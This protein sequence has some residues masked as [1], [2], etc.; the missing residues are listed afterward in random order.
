MRLNTRDVNLTAKFCLLSL[1]FQVAT[2]VHAQTI[3]C[4]L[5]D[6]PQGLYPSHVIDD[7]GD[8]DFPLVIGKS[9]QI[10]PGHF[11]NALEVSSSLDIDVP[12]MGEIRFGL[13]PPPI[14]SRVPKPAAMDWH[15]ADFGALMCSGEK[16]LRK[17]VGFKNPTH[18]RL[19][20][21]SFDWT[22]EFWFKSGSQTHQEAMVF[23]IGRGPLGVECATTS[24]HIRKDRRAFIFSNHGR[25]FRLKSDPQLLKPNSGQWSHFAF[26][27]HASKK[28]LVH[29]VNGQ[30]KSQRSGVTIKPLAKSDDGYLS[31]GK[32]GLWQKRLG[33]S[34][35]ELEFYEGVKYHRAFPVPSSKSQL[36][37][38]LPLAKGPSLLF[39]DTN[40]TVIALGSRKHLF[41]DDAFIQDMGMAEIV[42]NPPA[43]MERVIGN[44]KGAFR[45]HLTV[46][47]D[48]EGLIRIYN[49]VEDDFLA[50]YTS[51]DGVHFEEPKMG[52]TYKGKD[53]IVLREMVGGLGNPFID[54]NGP[55]EERW[56]YFSD[57]NRRGI[58]LYTSPDGY[59][60]S[61]HKTAILPFRSGTQSCTFYDDQQQKYISYHRS[62][63][64]HTPAKATQRSSVVVV[65]DDL[66][67]PHQ[68]KALSQAD[69][70]EIGKSQP[71][72]D[73]K[74]WY[75]DNGPLTPGGFGMEYPHA[76]DP[77]PEDPV[78]TDIYVTKATKYEWAPDTYLAFP[79][80]YF[81]YEADGPQTRQTLMDEA[82]G[83]GS[84]PIE[85]QL[86]VSRD[87]IR[88]KRYH[89]PVYIG[90]GIHAG[91]NVITAYIAHGMVKRGNE[92]WQYYFGE[93]QYHSAIKK[94][95]DGRGVYRLVQRIDGFVSVDSPYEKETTVLTKP[96]TFTG[97]RLSLNID[98]DAA[99]YAQ[100]GFLDD[101][102]KPISK[103]SVDDCVYINGDFTDA[104]VEWLNS[105]TDVSS[106]QGKTVQLVLKMRGSKLFALQFKSD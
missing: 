93:T 106:L 37:N 73:P 69:Y 25:S 77:V 61:R 65:L 70:I 103:F 72:R 52:P 41:I 8:N 27:Y 6:E 11:G 39:A 91:R 22:I 95:L 29:F 40:N 21:G 49:S 78:G 60:W 42:V 13:I 12:D 87:G 31:I 80:V 48:S 54:P 71:L 84:G 2:E 15:N 97:N 63:I 55:A 102:G 104:P 44:I 105:G 5:F 67:K 46:V 3:A 4:W 38:N 47:E 86:A 94:D 74:P 7:A 9:G 81:H 98:T 26:V 19:N 59:K 50:V 75:L 32:N 51:E 90:P 1:I 23:E 16:H 30:M 100:V 45:K 57:F 89:R 79:I 62:G 88:W 24:L 14:N 99:G 76:F 92:I 56:K 18:S 33:G 36:V 68:F 35:D 101:S 64:F 28:T 96:F 66:R 34:L 43:K 83:R 17:E 58:Y 82:R 85:S 10:V 53:N 20:L